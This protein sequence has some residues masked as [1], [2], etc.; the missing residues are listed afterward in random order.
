MGQYRETHS[1]SN[2]TDFQARGENIKY[3]NAEGKLEY[4]HMLNATALALGRTIIAILENYQ[5]E[6]GSI[7]MP[8]ALA[9]YLGFNKIV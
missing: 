3:R 9:P 6:D 7:T 1:A 2:T 4:V 5:E 8:E